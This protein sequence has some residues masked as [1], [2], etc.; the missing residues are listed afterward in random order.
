MTTATSYTAVERLFVVVLLCVKAAELSEVAAAMVAFLICCDLS[1]EKDGLGAKII[2][3][4]PA[5]IL[6][7]YVEFD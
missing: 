4:L 7:H 5:N 1:R 3:Q 2:Y 6:R